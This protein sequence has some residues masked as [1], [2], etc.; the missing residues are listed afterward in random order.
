MFGIIEPHPE[1]LPG[2]DAVRLYQL[3]AGSD[4]AVAITAIDRLITAGLE[5]YLGAF[6]A[7]GT[8]CRVHLARGA[9]AAAETVTRG[10]LCLA[11]FG[12]ALRFVGVT[13]GLEKF[14][15]LNAESECLAAI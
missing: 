2:P 12:T 9:V 11:A 1:R 13:F 15:V 14:L 10:F 5:G 4:F 6:A 8:G 7:F 3:P